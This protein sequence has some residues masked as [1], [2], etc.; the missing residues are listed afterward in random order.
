[1]NKKIFIPFILILVLIVGLFGYQK[2]VAATYTQPLYGAA[3]TDTTNIAAIIAGSPPSYSHPNYFTVTADMTSATWNTA[4]A[5]EIATV[6]GAVRMNIVVETVATIVTTGANGT[7]ALGYAGNTSAIFSATALDAAVTGDIWS[8]VYGSAATTLVGG[9]EA[10]G[11]LTHGIHN[12]VVL[13]G[14]DVG[15]TI[16]TNAATTGSLIFHIWWTPLNATG[17]VTAGAGGVL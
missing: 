10:G 16:A 4:A 11:S 17:N 5:H 3:G 1:M 6:T 7:M 14:V 13:N 2:L 12:V 8:A 9:A 15:Y